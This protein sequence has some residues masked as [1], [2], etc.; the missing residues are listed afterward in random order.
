MFSSDDGHTA[1]DTT[2]LEKAA[3]ADFTLLNN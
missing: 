2:V 1:L 3:S